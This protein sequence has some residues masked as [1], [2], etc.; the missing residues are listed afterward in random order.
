MLHNKDQYAVKKEKAIK[1]F[2]NIEK[3][4]YE[5]ALDVAT[6]LGE[7]IEELNIHSHIF[8]SGI[9]KSFARV[10]VAMQKRE[11]SVLIFPDSIPG[12]T[13]MSFKKDS[14]N[15]SELSDIEIKRDPVQELK[16]AKTMDL[17]VSNY[18]MKS[19]Q[20][21][22]VIESEDIIFGLF[23][24]EDTKKNLKELGIFVTY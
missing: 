17:V 9:E 20:K 11:Q 6:F 5:L 10:L 3:T 16:E 7:Q 24:V 4:A 12:F 19:K 22:L 13:L 2:G 21:V 14:Y 1:A 15:Q 18:F 8:R 23:P